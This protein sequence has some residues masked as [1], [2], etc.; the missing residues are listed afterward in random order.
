MSKASV[1]PIASALA[2]VL[3]LAPVGVQS[4]GHGP[5]LKPRPLPSSYAGQPPSARPPLAPA[6]AG[7][8]F[9]DSSFP[10][11]ANNT[12]F[13]LAVSGSDLYAGGDFTSIGGV[14]AN[15]IAKWSGSTHTWSP[16]GLGVDNR[17]RAVAEAIRRGLI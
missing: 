9:W 11:G 8:E 6:L 4:A 15:H 2:L 5:A 10:L 16:L 12:V 13:A 17:V 14:S 3:M 1:R 7:D